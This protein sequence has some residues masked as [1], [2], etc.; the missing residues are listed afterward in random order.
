ML[1]DFGDSQSSMSPQ[2]VRRRAAAA[3]PAAVPPADRETRARAGVWRSRAPAAPPVFAE[4]PQPR[5]SAAPPPNSEPPPGRPEPSLGIPPEIASFSSRQPDWTVP[6]EADTM[7]WTER[8]GRKALGWSLALAGIVAVAG[9]AAWMVRETKVESTLAIVAD[10]TP[11]PVAA[12]ATAVPVAQAESYEPPPLK[13]LPPEAPASVAAPE[14]PA[15]EPPVEA[16]LAATEAAAAAA[17]AVAAL[18]EKQ[19]AASPPP[20]KKKPAAKPAPQRRVAAAPAKRDKPV[21]KKTAKPK[22]PSERVLARA[23]ADAQRSRQESL[24]RPATPQDP[25]PSQPAATG[26]LAETLRLCRAAGYHATACI[27]RGCEATRF[28]LVCRG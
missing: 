14:K 24:A 17:P 3:S 12:P 21:V 8:W 23:L 9:T 16:A 1:E 27:K 2:P 6:L 26:A 28:G 15:S 5:V 10:H 19:E 22:A 11:A 4:P 7:P 18:P 20:V 13:L 25:A